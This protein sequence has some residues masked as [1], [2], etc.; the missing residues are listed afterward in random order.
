LIIKDFQAVENMGLSGK[1]IEF[2]EV[3]SIA[4]PLPVPFRRALGQ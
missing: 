3:F 2:G 4:L 1:I